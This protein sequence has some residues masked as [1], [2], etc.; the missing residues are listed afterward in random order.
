MPVPTCPRKDSERGLILQGI[1]CQSAPSSHVRKIKS[2]FG[3][4]VNLPSQYEHYEHSM[5]ISTFHGNVTLLVKMKNL[6]IS[7]KKMSI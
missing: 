6:G 3:I 7:K 4:L 2:R 1:K 5:N